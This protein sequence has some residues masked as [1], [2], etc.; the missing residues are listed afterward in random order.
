LRKNFEE[1][2]A[3]IGTLLFCLHPMQSEAVA[4]VSGRGDILAY[5]FLFLTLYFFNIHYWIAGLF[6][7]LAMMSKESMALIPIYIFAYNWMMKERFLLKKYF[8]V[9]IVSSFYIISRLTWLNFNNTLNFYSSPNLFTENIIYRIYTYFTTVAGAFRIWFFPYDLHH[10]RSWPV[11]V[12]FRSF[13]VLIGVSILV[14]TFMLGVLEFKKN[15][16]ALLLPALLW[17]LLA[18]FPTS[19]LLVLINAIFY[20][21]WFIL[22]GFLFLI[23]IIFYLKSFPKILYSVVIIFSF[24]TPFYNGV[25]KNPFTLYKHILKYEP[26]SAKAHNN[27]AMAY[28]DTNELNKAIEHYQ[29]AIK[30]SDTYAETHHNLANLYLQQ[31]RYKD[32][33]FELNLALKINSQFTPSLRLKNQILQKF[34]N[35]EN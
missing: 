4:Y 12:N 22:P 7:L 5:L 3:L 35:I 31:E 8:P 11:F 16:R 25:W 6:S 23:T 17:F 28:S 27:L 26:N 33:I 20:D 19:N 9:I 2:I 18:S 15:K 34:P 21:H 24:I 14:I 32:A 30:I 1:K 13:E 29:L 10:E